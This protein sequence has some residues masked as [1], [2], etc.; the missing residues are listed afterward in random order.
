MYKYPP[1]VRFNLGKTLLIP[2]ARTHSASINEVAFVPDS[3]NLFTVS[4]DDTIRMFDERGNE[5]LIMEGHWAPI[6]DM[7]LHPKRR[8]IATASMDHTAKLWDPAKKTWTHSFDDATEPLNAVAFSTD[9]NILFTGGR[10][11]HLRAYDLTKTDKPLL[12]HLE[13]SRI[14][15]LTPHPSGTLLMVGTYSEVVVVAVPTGEVLAK[16]VG[17]TF[18]VTGIAFT[19]D[20]KDG[21]TYMVTSS[22][23]EQVKVWDPETLEEKLSFRPHGTG[24]AVNSVRF[25]PTNPIYAT[26]SF[27]QAVNVYNLRETKPLARLR[28]PRLSIT[29][30]AWNSSGSLL[31]YGSVDGSLTV[32]KV[33]ETDVVYKLERNRRIATSMVGAPDGQSLFLGFEDGVVRQVGLGGKLMR[34]CGSCHKGEVTWMQI[35]KA[36]PFKYLVVTSGTDRTIKVWRSEPWGLVATFTGHKN[37]VKQFIFSPDLTY[38]LS[39]SAD[40]TV[41]KF[42]LT[43]LYEGLEEGRIIDFIVPDTPL[44]LEE[45]RTIRGHNHSVNSVLFSHHGRY[46]ATASNDHRVLLFDSQ[47][48]ST[49][50]VF[51]G[52]SDSVLSLYFSPDDSKLYTGSMNGNLLV[53]DVEKGTLL[54]KINVHSDAIQTISECEI[55]NNYF[56]TLSDDDTCTLF[57]T[58]DENLGQISFGGNVKALVWDLN[59][60]GYYISTEIGELY[61]VEPTSSELEVDL[62]RYKGSD[63]EDL[64]DELVEELNRVEELREIELAEGN[65]FS[66]RFLYWLVSRSNWVT[67]FMQKYGKDE[68][69]R[70]PEIQ[71]YLEEALAEFPIEMV[72]PI[73]KLLKSG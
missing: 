8:V 41:R 31:A 66:G 38:L 7:V 4:S 37:S 30:V 6:Q 56:V 18:P 46:F 48:E 27:N 51:K 23:D 19:T 60:R 2:H 64:L 40:A 71:A 28:G 25:H 32:V 62:A 36:S 13:L 43:P 22:L 70:V 33:P 34:E 55:D 14:F 10:D 5:K 12:Y 47:K 42:S 67:T 68:E 63:P 20:P 50:R 17:H 54:K 73:K 21:K 59:K 9:G 24:G 44:V 53:F 57:S 1:A 3:E 16:L 29:S 35:L 15:S 11:K 69:G 65:L 52:H 49:I 61:L 72:E 58:F 45:E 26:A 39:C